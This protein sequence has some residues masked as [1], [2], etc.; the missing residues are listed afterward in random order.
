MALLAAGI[1]AGAVA[2]VL[3]RAWRKGSEDAAEDL[4]PRVDV[5]AYNDALHNGW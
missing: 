1:A 5:A 2:Y 4:L 3:V